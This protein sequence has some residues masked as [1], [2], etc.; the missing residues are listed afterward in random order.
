MAALHPHLFQSSVTD[1]SEIH[2]LVV[3]HFLPDRAVLQWH[4]TAGEDIPTPN[5]TEIVVF[6]SFFQC[7]FGLPTCDFLG[8]LLDHY[9]IK[10]VHLNPNS[11]P[12]IVV[13]VHLCEA[14]LGISP[15][16]PLFKNYFF[17]KYQ[18][19]ATNRKVIGGIGLQT[20]HRAG[21]LDLPMQSSLRGWHGTWF[22]CEN[23]E[24]IL[25]SFVGRLLEFQGTWSEE[26]TPLEL[27]Q[28]AALTN[29]VNRLKE[30]GLMGVYVAAHWLARRVQP[31][32][33]QVHSG[34]EYSGLQDPTRETRENITPELLVKHLGELFQDTS[35]WLTD[36]QVRSYHIMVEW[37]PVRRPV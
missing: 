9:R 25:P 7:R 12:Q 30:K 10:L 27:P 35:S 20:R 3:N 23:Y 19:S 28:V 17:L 31:L 24:P 8:G 33:K 22:Y 5:T 6:S 26:S 15:N 4:P 14:F 37:V 34:W 18:P 11:V 32:K 29:K 21:F 16:F 36:E 13:F 1:E 2:K